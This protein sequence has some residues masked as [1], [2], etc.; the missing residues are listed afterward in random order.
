[1]NQDVAHL[2]ERRMSQARETLRAA[3]VLFTSGHYRD[4]VNRAYYAMFY[5]GL[6]LLASRLIGASKHSGVLSLFGEHFVK[7]GRFSMEAG[8]H[9]RMAF[10]LRQKSDYREDFCPT[11]EQTQEVVAQAEDFLEEADRVWADMRTNIASPTKDPLTE[12]T[13]PQS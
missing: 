6:G 1:V 12:G 11:L 7:T 5:A 3:R 8:R 4:C 10:E 9:L 2:V 13:Q